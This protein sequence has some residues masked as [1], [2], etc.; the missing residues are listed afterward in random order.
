MYIG[1][2]SYL[3]DIL[4]CGQLSLLQDEVEMHYS[5]FRTPHM[6]NLSDLVQENLGEQVGY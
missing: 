6:H 5:G 4:I 1:H 2:T 3:A